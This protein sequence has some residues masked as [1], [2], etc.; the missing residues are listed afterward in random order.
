MIGGLACCTSFLTKDR[1]SASQ[2]FSGLQTV[3]VL[4][5][6]VLLS[7]ELVAPRTK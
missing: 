5:V 2:E 3:V 4:K 6:V 1:R 7:L